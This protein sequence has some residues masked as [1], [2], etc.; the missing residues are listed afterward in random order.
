[1]QCFINWTAYL[2]ISESETS[3]KIDSYCNNFQFVGDGAKANYTTLK[4]RIWMC[5][6]CYK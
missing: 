4:I 3:V 5:A 6:Q 1:M 2:K